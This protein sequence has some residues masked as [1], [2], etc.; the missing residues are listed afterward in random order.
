M[1]E[2]ATV[3]GEITE[4]LPVEVRTTPAQA[5]IEAVSSLLAKAVA[6][7]SELQLTPEETAALKK[8]FPDEAFRPG[9]GGNKTLIYIEHIHLRNRLDDVLGIGQ[10]VIV[11]RSRWTEE[12]EYMKDGYKKTG[13]RVFV[14]AMFIVRGCY[15]TEAVGE[16]TYYPGNQGA[17]YSDAVEGAE[18]AALRRC[19]KKFGVGLQA[20]SKTWCD[21]WWARKGTQTPT[22]GNQQGEE[23]N[24]EGN[25]TPMEACP[26]CGKSDSV[27]QGKAE[28]GGGLV[29]F[30]KKNGGCGHKWAGKDVRTG[31]DAAPAATYPPIMEEWKA[32]LDD[33]G[34]AEKLT[35]LAKGEFAAIPG[36]H[37]ER[38]K[39]WAMFTKFAE[40]MGWT[41][42]HGEKK[43][44][45][46]ENR[47]D[48]TKASGKASKQDI[49]ADLRTLR[50]KIETAT[51]VKG[52][53]LRQSLPDGTPIMPGKKK[54][55][56]LTA[57]EAAIVLKGLNALPDANAIGAPG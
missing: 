29:C 41:F 38:A 53:S 45:G 22:D 12:F 43:F 10:A 8:E 48:P 27:I 16:M 15:I 51:V 31:E 39:V 24:Y 35:A 17:D 40:G 56:E 21:G 11:P 7:A 49:Q 13:I 42:S 54:L 3:E 36:K 19:C 18:T 37:P 14:E 32:K 46:A 23:R 50:E 44:L 20:W 55:A 57:E 1:S 26:K 9:A 30:K 4:H 6:R 52:V 33:C 47:P 28:Y 25:Q 5:K 34:S 2:L